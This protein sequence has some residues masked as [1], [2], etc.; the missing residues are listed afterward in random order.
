MTHCSTHRQRGSPATEHREQ[1]LDEFNHPKG[2]K[3]LQQDVRGGGTTPNPRE[4]QLHMI[5]E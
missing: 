4:E 5:Y 3:A 1:Q 2:E